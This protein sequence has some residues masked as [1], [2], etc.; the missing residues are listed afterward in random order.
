MPD[1]EFGNARH[2][3]RRARVAARLALDLKKTYL[4]LLG[5]QIGA[6]YDQH[7]KE[8]FTFSG[9]PLTTRRTASSWRTN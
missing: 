8:L 4:A 2:R 9:Q 6:F 5:E 3:A 1:Q 7:S